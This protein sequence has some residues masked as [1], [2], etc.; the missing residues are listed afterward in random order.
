MKFI[1]RE[2][3]PLYLQKG[4][5]YEAL[6]PKDYEKFGVPSNCL[7]LDL[8]ITSP[9]DLKHLLFS[10]RF[11]GINGVPA[12]VLQYCMLHFDA[13]CFT[14]VFHLQELPEY[15]EYFRGVL[16]LRG[17]KPEETVY[18]AITMKF[19][20]HTVKVLHE[21][22]KL[23]MSSE[24]WTRA[25]RVDDAA[26]MAYLEEKNVPKEVAGSF[27]IM[28]AATHGSVRCLKFMHINNWKIPDE[29]LVFAADNGRLE[30]VKFLREVCRKQYTK[31][32]MICAAQ[33][34]QL[35]L[36]RYLHET[37]CS[38]DAEICAIFACNDQLE[39]LKF[40]HEA[41]CAWDVRTCRAAAEAGHLRCLK[42][43]HT[44]GCPWDATVSKYAISAK[45]RDCPTMHNSTA[46][47]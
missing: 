45:Q 15:E 12:Q 41:G 31:G 42:Y 30:C 43:A 1:N 17:S 10:L 19:G 33:H 25:A 44:Q 26:T 29:I 8:T 37:G 24:C 4:A 11:W 16:A 5:F 22:M 47:Q 34:G 46:A 23:K 13:A 36:L 6:D 38:W 18:L 28:D 27:A 3:V 20:V 14:Q 9:E 39:C 32:V 2:E 40:A 35:D 21:S 7:K